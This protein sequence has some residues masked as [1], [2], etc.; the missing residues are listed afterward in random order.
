[1]AD[2][3]RCNNK[4]VYESNCSKNV[5]TPIAK[6]ILYIAT[7]DCSKLLP[8]F[9]VKG[10]S[11]YVALLLVKNDMYP[12]SAYLQERPLGQN[13]PA[14]DDRTHICFKRHPL[15]QNRLPAA[16]HFDR[17]KLTPYKRHMC[18]HATMYVAAHLDHTKRKQKT[19]GVETHTQKSTHVLT[20]V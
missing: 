5:H 12:E 14:A 9:H 1:M 15:G 10:V 3:Q 11:R 4:L 2:L 6:S 16:G 8:G 13:K 7:A 17:S 18:C 19:I 20:H